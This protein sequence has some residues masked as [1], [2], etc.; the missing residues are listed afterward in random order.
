MSEPGPRALV[1][2]MGIGAAL[3]LVSVF[4]PRGPALAPTI[5]ADAVARVDGQA[6][7]RA[8]YERAIAALA[9][10]LRRPLEFADRE[11]VVERLVDELLLV[12]HGLEREL[13]QRDPYLRTQVARA[14]LDRLQAQ[15]QTGAALSEAE[16]RDHYAAAGGRFARVGRI[17]LETLY[18]GP[19][20]Q[21]RAQA[22]ASEWAA[23]AEHAELLARADAPVLEL[24]AAALTPDKLR[25]YL[26]PE[27]A[28]VALTL[29]P[30]E[31]SEVLALAGGLWILRVVAREPGQLPPFAEVRELVAA[32]LERERSDR[33][34]RELLDE[35]RAHSEIE[36]A[37]DRL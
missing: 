21:T 20:E 17:E 4:V 27:V 9:S 1:L 28:A 22:L 5:P 35:L 3:A 8:D 24:P 29:A 16:L 26:G 33:A 30:G 2:A 25:D 6:I 37:W 15:I 11:Q 23:G 13:V 32:D 31:V 34:L 14:V 10:D 7:P 18:L 36:V 19:S 12:E